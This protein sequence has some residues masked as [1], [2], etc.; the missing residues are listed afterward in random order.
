[1]L[2]VWPQLPTGL[3][4]KNGAIIVAKLLTYVGEEFVHIVTLLFNLCFC[5][6]ACNM[7]FS[8]ILINK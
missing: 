8:I 1:M 4:E 7:V 6:T 3:N 5:I 2:M